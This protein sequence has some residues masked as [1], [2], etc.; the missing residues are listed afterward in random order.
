MSVQGIA[1]ILKQNYRL[2]LQSN[3]DFTLGYHTMGY[4][5]FG[6]AIFPRYTVETL[7]HLLAKFDMLTKPQII[8]DTFSITLIPLQFKQVN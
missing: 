2:L 5:F 3:A 8:K 4:T 7:K 1:A 6:S